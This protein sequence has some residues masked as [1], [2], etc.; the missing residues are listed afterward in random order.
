[1]EKENLNVDDVKRIEETGQ[2]KENKKVS[3]SKVK[4]SDVKKELTPEQLKQEHLDKLKNAFYAM[5]PSLK[6]FKVLN[7]LTGYTVEDKEGK[8]FVV[9]NYVGIDM[10]KVTLRDVLAMME[11]IKFNE[12]NNI[13]VNATTANLNQLLDAKLSELIPIVRDEVLKEAGLAKPVEEEE[14]EPVEIN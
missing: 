12:T 9:H 1:M 13:I 3:P 14:E 8:R 11:E 10:A 2:T 5:Y 4:I 6:D 7:Q